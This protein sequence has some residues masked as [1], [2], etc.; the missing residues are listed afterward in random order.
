MSKRSKQRRLQTIPKSKG[1]GKGQPTPKTQPI[2]ITITLHNNKVQVHGCP[3]SLDLA[4]DIIT[5]GLRIVT[6]GFVEALVKQALQ[7]ET[8]KPEKREYMGARDG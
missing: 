5:Q 7:H 4:L 8:P 2:S 6:K 1:N 3:S